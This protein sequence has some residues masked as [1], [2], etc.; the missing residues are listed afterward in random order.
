MTYVEEAKSTDLKTNI[1]T[2]EA[3]YLANVPKITIH[4]SAI[5][6]G[7]LNFDKKHNGIGVYAAGYAEWTISGEIFG[8][9]GVYV[10][11]GIVTLI[12]A[13]I[14]SIWTD[15]F[16]PAEATTSGAVSGGSG[17]VI[18]SSSS[19]AGKTQVTVEGDT[20]IEGNTGYG[21][22]QSITNG[23]SQQ[24]NQLKCLYL[25]FAF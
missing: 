7:G 21:I 9:T 6:E 22:E 12:D 4:P 3:A 14:Y 15:T 13:N 24:L 16:A 5:V 2:N 25:V 20:K 17:V 1:E 11:D 10:K 23:T 18:E 8:A 19:Y